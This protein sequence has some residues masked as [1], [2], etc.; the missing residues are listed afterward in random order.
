M[1]QRK[2]SNKDSVAFWYL[3]KTIKQVQMWWKK[4]KKRFFTLFKTEN[5]KILLRK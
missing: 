1:L 3:N 5:E 4:K 2:K